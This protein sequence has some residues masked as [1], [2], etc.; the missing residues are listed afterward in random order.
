VKGETGDERELIAVTD[1]RLGHQL[2]F[3]LTV[4]V[5]RVFFIAYSG[6]ILNS[7]RTIVLIDR[8]CADL[9]MLPECHRTTCK[10]DKFV[11]EEET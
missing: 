11:C 9:T 5:V 3:K 6:G 1:S 7:E 2:Q 10:C 8:L 4:R